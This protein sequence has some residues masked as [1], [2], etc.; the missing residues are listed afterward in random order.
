MWPRFGGGVRRRLGLE[1]FGR[2]GETRDGV[3]DL[4]PAV[5][6]YFHYSVHRAAHHA[7]S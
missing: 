1:A 5:S 2:G 6:A 7:D 3:L 4:V